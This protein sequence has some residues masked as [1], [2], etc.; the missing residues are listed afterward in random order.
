MPVFEVYTGGEKPAKFDM[1]DRKLIDLYVEWLK[2][3]KKQD[4]FVGTDT[5]G[6]IAAVSFHQVAAIKDTVPAAGAGMQQGSPAM[7]GRQIS[8]S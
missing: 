1:P 7:G 5:H 3:K 6:Q 2:D 8:G 4:F